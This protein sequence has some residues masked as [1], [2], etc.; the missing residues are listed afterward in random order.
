MK[1]KIIAPFD[2]HAHF[3]TDD[4]LK[5]V[6]GC[7][8]KIFDDAVFMGN[9][10]KPV[11]DLYELT[12]YYWKIKKALQD[13]NIPFFNPTMTI[14]LTLNTTIDTI[15]MCALYAKVL[16]FIPASTSTN[17]QLGIRLEDLEKYYDVL[18]EVRNQNMIFSIHA[19]RIT[20]D[21]GQEIPD[22]DREEAA[23][24]FIEK[25]IHDI[26]RLKIVIEHVSTK[27]AC[28][29]VLRS[30]D[31]VAATIT[32]HHVSFNDS[33]LY[34]SDGAINPEYYCKPVLKSEENRAFV[35]SMMLSGNPKFFFGSD[36]APHPGEMKFK[37]SPAAGIFSAPV[38]LPLIIEK[39]YQAGEL[40]RLENFVSVF[41]RKF[42][43]LKIPTRKV[44]ITNENLWMVP[45]KVGREN[46]P[47]LMGGTMMQWSVSEK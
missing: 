24:P 31:N 11:D 42:Y 38:A 18:K 29:L 45:E 28:E 43:G 32:S 5:D 16:K 26:P 8:A 47:V 41:G 19:E 12:N 13:Q 44:T 17:A 35:E 3:R 46:V 40:R 30:S 7:T 39:F 37:E 4:M 21:N 2:A 25:L 15:K 14:M 33:M 23:L 20:D 10:K 1:Q 6:I 22:A 36:T 27:K 9:L 34:N